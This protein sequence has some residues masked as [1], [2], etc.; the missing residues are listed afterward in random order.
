MK[1]RR[2]RGYL[3]I[4]LFLGLALSACAG[5]TESTD[6]DFHSGELGQIVP[7]E[8]GGSYLDIIPS[9]LTEMLRANDFFFVKVHIPNEGEI[10]GTEAHI[11]FDQVTQRL[12][13][14]PTQKDAKIV[15]Y[16]RSGSMSAT[17]AR[18]LVEVG[19]TNVLNLDGGYRA[20]SEAGYPFNP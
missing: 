5:A 8:G 10:P 15:L 11:A 6:T 9:E 17:A 7:L 14:F 18:A 13:E 1:A 2:K 4:V 16:C 20:W 12:D 3:S 19:Y